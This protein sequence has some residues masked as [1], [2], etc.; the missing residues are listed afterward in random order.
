IPTET[1]P[2]SFDVVKKDVVQTGQNQIAIVGDSITWT[3]NGEAFRFKLAYHDP[4]LNFIGTHTDTFGFGH[5]GE[6]GNTTLDVI[7]RLPRIIASDNYLVH[8]GT[9]DRLAPD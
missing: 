2:M 4:N 1:G 6:G 5:E 8:I 3:N 9:N 7:N